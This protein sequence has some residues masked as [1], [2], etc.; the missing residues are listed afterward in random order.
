[1]FSGFVKAL[2]PLGMEHKLEA[3]CSVVGLNVMAGSLYL[4]VAVILLALIEFTLGVYLLLGMRQRTAAYGAF[5]FMLCMTAVTFYIYAFDPVPD[6]GCFGAAIT[7]SNGETLTKNIVMLA[8]TVLIIGQRRRSLRIISKHNQWLLSAYALVYMLGIT[9]YSLHYLPL[10]DFTGYALGTDIPKA[11]EGE[12]KVTFIYEKNGKRKEFSEDALP[13]GSWKYVEATTTVV[14]APSI[15]DFFIL[16][17]KGE[18]LTDEVLSDTGFVFIAT[19]PHLPTADPGCSDALNDV[20]DYSVDRN[21]RFYCATSGT[22]KDISTWIDRTG[23]AYPFVWSSNETLKAMVRSN[24]GLI[25]LKGGRI[26]AKWGNNNMPDDAELA[27]LSASV[28][29]IQR[30]SRQHIFGKLFLWFVVPFFLLLLL[31]RIWIGSR[32]YKIHHHY[33]SLKKN[34][35]P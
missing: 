21:C 13:D 20:Y 12:Y 18:E 2:D 30:E 5:V 9:L 4:D 26:I 25:L 8:L 29:T 1:M 3:Y 31:D 32:Y 28:E 34:V 24:P 15:S 27:S 6:C 17:S 33:K 10:I 23:A 16:N 11:M 35:S 14:T 19:I 7:L 22:A